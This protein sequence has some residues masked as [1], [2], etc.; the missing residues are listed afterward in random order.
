[1]IRI[2]LGLLIIITSVAV[3]LYFTVILIPL[4]GFIA[5]FSNYKDGAV[6]E[7][8]LWT[9]GLGVVDILGGLLIYSGFKKIR[10][11]VN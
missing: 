3:Y 9:V 6:P 11:T 10:K 8:V 7:Y 4:D 5:G 2:W 1:M